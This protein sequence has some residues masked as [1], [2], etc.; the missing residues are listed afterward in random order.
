M[1][2][3]KTSNNNL[4]ITVIYIAIEYLKKHFYFI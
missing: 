1:F 3:L 2:L 4:Q